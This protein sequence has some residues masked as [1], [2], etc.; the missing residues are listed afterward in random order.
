MPFT[1]DR[2]HVPTIRSGSGTVPFVGAL[3]PFPPDF[4]WSHWRALVSSFEGNILQARRTSDSAPFNAA[5]LANGE[6]DI[7][8]LQSFAGSG[9]AAV[10]SLTEQM[11]TMVDFLQTTGDSQR[12]IV[13]AGS[14]V[15]VG[16]KA[17]SRG[18]RFIISDPL[19]GG[20]ETG[21]TAFTYTG[22][23]LSIFLRGNKSGYAGSF[24]DA[25][26]DV[27]FGATADSNGST[28][29]AGAIGFFRAAQSAAGNELTVGS[30]YGALSLT[31]AV[32]DDY[33]VSIIFDGA[34]ATI[35][36]DSGSSSI[37][38]SNNF[39]INRFLFG[40][41]NSGGGQDNCSSVH[42]WQEAAVWLSDQSSNE[43][44]I[45]SALMA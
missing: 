34:N 21:T 30:N 1:P 12:I 6:A 31:K 36:D 28:T 41:F 7:A 18:R 2:F 16:G 29:T 22:T 45:R 32:V 42:R 11:G 14:L 40:L 5:R 20:M 15:T 27:G 38:F 24:Y 37:S 13:D 4:T 35:T 9:T 19:G 25:I 23:T 33:L 17:A 39:A 3:D 44:A 8:G 43:A 10:A 26:A